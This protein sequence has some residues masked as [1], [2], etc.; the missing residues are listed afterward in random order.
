M[1]RARLGLFLRL[2]LL[3]LL[4]LA[5]GLIAA[6]VLDASRSERLVVRAFDVPEAVARTG[7]TGE[8]IAGVVADELLRLKS[9]GRGAKLPADSPLQRDIAVEPEPAGVSVPALR[10]LLRESLGNDLRIGG[11]LIRSEDGTLRLTVRG[12]GVQPRS[13]SGPSRDLPA[14]A[15]RAAGH[16]FGSSSPVDYLRQLNDSGRPEAASAFAPRALEEA[17]GIQE[18][19]RIA[20]LWAEA[21]LQEGRHADARERA[22][23][24]LSLDPQN[25]DARAVLVASAPNEE[26]G[27]AESRKLRETARAAPAGRTMPESLFAPEHRLRQDWAAL[28]GLPVSAAVRAEAEARRHHHQAASRALA[29]ADGAEANSGPPADL[30]LGLRELDL[31]RA[32][33]AIPPLERFRRAA[34][35]SPGLRR[36][37]ADAACQLALAYARVG[38]TAEARRILRGAPKTA[39]CLAICGDV[40]ALSGNW[41]AA[42]KAYRDAIAAVPSSP[43]PYE[44]AGAALLAR[45]EAER[46][47]QLF[48]AAIQR[49][50]NWADPR[51]GLAEALMRLGR[52]AE[53]EREYAAAARPAPR[54]GALQIGWGEALWRLGRQQE[55]VERWR[56]ASAMD[57]SAAGR[58]RLQQLLTLTR[59]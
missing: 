36:I 49:G 50:P 35:D 17:Q 15:A 29:S 47:A 4:L 2:V 45:D 20:S 34:S 55:A 30:I 53:A 14:L 3:A 32:D 9:E 22:R 7:A 38:Q 11:S 56:S 10:R 6:W 54:W 39:L 27:L 25:V 51:F 48:R 46:A 44:R 57:L 59:S 43:I 41:R 13:F 21:L 42:T 12:D 8:A 52:F 31:G 37:R 24:A 23:Q 18:K 1:L 19:S 26:E 5:A 33:R 16:V 40:L 28:A 58:V